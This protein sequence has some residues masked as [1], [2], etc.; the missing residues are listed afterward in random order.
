LFFSKL[1]PAARKQ[2]KHWLHRRHKKDTV[3]DLLPPDDAQVAFAAAAEEVQT[4]A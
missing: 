2:L 4:E 3:R 1:S